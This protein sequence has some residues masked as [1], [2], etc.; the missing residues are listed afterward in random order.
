[1]MK[2]DNSGV[3]DCRPCPLTGIAFAQQSATLTPS[4]GERLS[5]QLMDLGGVGYTVRVDGQERQI[6]ANDVAAIDFTGAS[7]ST[8]DWDKL[9]GGGQVLM[10]EERRNHHRPARGHRRIVAAANDL[11]DGVR[12][13]RLLVERHRPDRHVPSG[14]C[15]RDERHG[16]EQRCRD[17]S[18]GLTVSSQQA[19]DADRRHSATR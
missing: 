5:A 7:I 17:R 4:P 8:A 11:P 19:V 3:V 10:L 16:R 12:R 15:R 9:S 6:P 2:K 14:Q 18:Q 1:M 13:A